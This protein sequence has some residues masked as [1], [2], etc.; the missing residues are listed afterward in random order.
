MYNGLGTT[1]KVVIRTCFLLMVIEVEIDGRKAYPLDLHLA[2]LL[3]S[4]HLLVFPPQLPRKVLTLLARPLQLH[5][6]D[7]GKEMDI[8]IDVRIKPFKNTTHDDDLHSKRGI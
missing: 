3:H 2:L 1:E 6:I 7:R 4:L 5:C 8:T